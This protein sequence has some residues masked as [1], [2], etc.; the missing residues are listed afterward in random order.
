MSSFGTQPVDNSEGALVVMDKDNSV[1]DHED[2]EVNLF[3]V[4]KA[5]PLDKVARPLNSFEKPDLEVNLF[6]VNQDNQLENVGGAPVDENNME[7][8][9]DV[10]ITLFQQSDPSHLS[11]VGDE[12]NMEEEDEVE[13]T[14]V[15]QTD[16]SNLSNVGEET[17]QPNEN[18]NSEENDVQLAV[19]QDNQSPVLGNAVTPTNNSHDLNLETQLPVMDDDSFYTAYAS[20]SDTCN[21]GVVPMVRLDSVGNGVVKTF[22]YNGQPFDSAKQVKEKVREHSIETRRELLFLMNDKKR[23][24][25][26]CCGCVPLPSLLGVAGPGIGPVRGPLT[27]KGLEAL[28]AGKND[29]SQILCP[30]LLLVGRDGETESWSMERQW[31]YGMSLNDPEFVKGVESF[32][33]AAESNRVAKGDIEIFCPCS[34]CK[35]FEP[36]TDIKTIEWHLHRYGFVRKYTCWSEHGESL[37]G[38]STSSHVSN[39]NENNDS[40]I[41]DKHENLKEMLHDLEA[42]DGDIDQEDLQQLKKI[43]SHFNTKFQSVLEQVALQPV[44]SY[45]APQMQSQLATVEPVKPKTQEE[46]YKERLDKLEDRPKLFKE[47]ARRFTKCKNR[48][49]PIDA[50]HNM[51]VKPWGEWIEYEAVL[52]IHIEAKVDIT[53]IHWWAMHLHSIVNGLHHNRCVFLNPHLIV[54][55]ECLSNSEQVVDHIISTKGKNPGKD[56]YV[57]PYLQGGSH[58]LLFV[59]CPNLRR[60]YIVD[61]SK[62]DNTEENYYFPKIVERAF[63]IKFDWTMAKCFQQK[64]DWECGYYLMKSMYDLA[65]YKQADFPKHVLELENEYYGSVWLQVIDLSSKNLT[66][67]IPNE[68]TNLHGIISIRLVKQLSRW[69][70]STRHWSEMTAFNFEFI[71][72]HVFIAKLPKPVMG[73]CNNCGGTG[74][75]F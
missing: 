49:I 18:N 20:E 47:S 23:I 24:R 19:V 41:N 42:N 31:M 60:G 10:E 43:Q 8:E 22:F 26:K 67:E 40:C 57:A 28:I 70:D 72:K 16:P 63:E 25:V 29:P 27:R 54:S 13:I 34:K 11:N 45:T 6:Q 62:R 68:V 2:F 38:N 30:W 64:G 21:A 66:G 9:D 12:N 37:V 61:S 65:L 17:M 50:P 1:Q 5:K 52:D 35:N 3:R 59:V 51:Y 39:T 15:Q 32:L 7:E 75:H 69:K 33:I 71:K 46:R 53:F 74:P 36:F 14:L 73:E 4:T 58:W 48:N 56:I 44:T 55:S